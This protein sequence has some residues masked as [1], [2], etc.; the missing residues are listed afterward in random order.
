MKKFFIV[1]SF[2]LILT[3]SGC[4]KYISKNDAMDVAMKDLG[5]IQINV[6][7][8]T[9]ELDKNSDPVSYKI[10][11]VFAS[12]DYTYI[13]NAETGAILSKTTPK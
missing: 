7:D 11:F 6:S 8:L 12:K 10:D 13:V 9:A 1:M 3:L 2:V 5:L 4:S